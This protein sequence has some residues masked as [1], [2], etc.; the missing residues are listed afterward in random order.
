MRLWLPDGLDTRFGIGAGSYR[1]ISTEP[2]DIQDGSAWR[3]DRHAPGRRAAPTRCSS[4]GGCSIGPTTAEEVEVDGVPAYRLAMPH[5]V[6]YLR[7]SDRLPLRVEL[8]GGTVQRYRA[9][10]WLPRRACSSTCAEPLSQLRGSFV[11]TAMKPILP[12]ALAA[13]LLLPAPASRRHPRRG[14]ARVRATRG[15][16]TCSAAAGR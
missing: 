8:E 9:V 6:A 7:R 13:L 1:T 2:H 4:T 5:Q 10:E 16:P 14:R 12:I 3:A 11:R 15:W